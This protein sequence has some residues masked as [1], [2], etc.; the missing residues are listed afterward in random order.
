MKKSFIGA[1]VILILVVTSLLASCTTS[2]TTK[3]AASTTS[4]QSTVQTSSQTTAQTTSSTA[5]NWWDKFGTPQY[6]GSV[7]FRFGSVSPTW[8]IMTFMGAEFT[9]YFEYLAMRNW[10][11]DRS[12]CDMH[13]YVPAK[14]YAG[15]LAERWEQNDPNTYTFY[16]RHGITFQN[17]A[18][19]NGRELTAYDI[20]EHYARLLGTGHGYTVGSPMFAG[21]L[22]NWDSITAT[23]KYTLVFKV[24]KPSIQSF[25]KILEST[26]SNGIE[27]PEAVKAEGGALTD[28]TK[29]VGTGPWMLTDYVEGN[30]VTFTKN[31]NY[32]GY[33]ERHP[34]NKLP[35]TDN[36]KIFIIPD[37]STA[38]AAVRT[39]KTDTMGG[40]SNLNLTWEQA[41]SLEKTNP[42]MSKEPIAGMGYTLNIRVDK[43]PFGDIRVRKALNMAIDRPAGLKTYYHNAVDGNACGIVNPVIKGYCYAY[44]DWPQALKD[45]YTYNPTK[46]KELLAAAGYPDGFKTSVVA[47]NNFDTNLLQVFKANMADVGIDMEIS[48]MDFGTFNEMVVLGKHEALAWWKTGGP[49]PAN[50]DDYVTNARMNMGR[51]VDPKVDQ[52]AD[53]ITYAATDEDL[54]K[55]SI[56]AD[57]YMFEQHYLAPSCYDMAYCFWSPNFKG[58]SGEETHFT[59]SYVFARLW[60]TSK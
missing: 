54:R 29:A 30:Q 18:P 16:L 34:E 12:I 50:L 2:T 44:S 32:W 6:G 19:V 23:D 37:I 11:T 55:Y 58:F 59:M 22:A 56:E 43:A 52:L 57:K 42:E 28:W 5:A 3:T 60:K 47:P 45:E 15:L 26:V 31:P 8:D 40:D 48:V 46:A 21:R 1:I 33:D 17:K 25:T 41:S 27:A 24:K 10:T 35:Y 9:L 14:Y 38:M 49:G 36:V 7:N 13:G 53:Q 20:E 51:I 4:T 39:G